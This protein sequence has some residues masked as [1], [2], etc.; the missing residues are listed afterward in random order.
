MVVRAS[1]MDP[2][3]RAFVE[4]G[5]WYHTLD[6]AEG[7]R[8]RGVFDHRPH[9]SEYGFPPDLAGKT[10]LDAGTGD[11]FFAFELERRGAKGV[12]AI[13]TDTYDGRP[14]HSDISPAKVVAYENKYS[15]N[16]AAA[17]QWGDVAAAFG[18]DVPNRRLIARDL[19][20]SSVEFRTQSVYDLAAA[21]ERFDVVFCGDLIEHLKHPLAALENL[22]SATGE[23]CI[24]SLSNALPAGRAAP[25]LRRA[26]R[27]MIGVLGVDGYLAE[28]S[29]VAQ[30]VGNHAGGAFFWFHP[31]AFR[32]ALLASGFSRV[33]MRTEFDLVH[34]GTG[35]PIRHAIF[36][37][38]P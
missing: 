14:G 17:E 1:T 21:G 13:D 6:L 10:A 8:T 24:V 26:I 25:R 32:A 29:S 34:R 16:V 9:V 28:S 5:Y 38:T 20:G 3:V 37:C 2:R 31:N 19:L 23:L 27:K 35:L 33:R 11:G 7:L 15:V 36:H 18:L 12:V 4:E 22:R 30:Y